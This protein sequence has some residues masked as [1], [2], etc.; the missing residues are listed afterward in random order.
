MTCPAKAPSAS[1]EPGRGHAR[2]LILGRIGRVRCLLTRDQVR[3]TVRPERRSFRSGEG[4]RQ[5]ECR[6]AGDRRRG[7]PKDQGERAL[8]R[9]P[10]GA[11]GI[12]LER[13]EG[14]PP[15]VP[16]QGDG[17]IGLGHRQRHSHRH[18]DR[19]DRAD[20]RQ[21]VQALR[22]RLGL[23]R[24]GHGLAGRRA[25]QAAPGGCHPGGGFRSP[26]GLPGGKFGQGHR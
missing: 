3:R 2:A 5:Q 4:V 24:Q 13:R 10:E 14:A 6:G 16:D 18:G 8:S 26:G 15:S 11:P 19:R 23:R 25:E 22:L 1:H 9:R 20:E 7:R 17:S 12:H 21:A